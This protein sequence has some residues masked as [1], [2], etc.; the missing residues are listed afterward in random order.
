[1]S[2]ARAL[3]DEFNGKDL[4]SWNLMLCAFVE[5][6]DMV[7]ARKMFDE[8]SQKDVVSWSIMIDGYG[9]KTG[10]V[11]HARSLF[12]Q[13]N[14]RDMVTW[15]TMIDSYVKVG[16]M[17]AARELFDVMEHRNVI[18]WSSMINGYS[19]HGDPKEALN[20]YNQMLSH[21]IKADKF[22]VV[23][24]ISSCAQLGALDQGR[25]IHMYLKKKKITV[26]IVVNTALVDMYMKC[27]STEEA[28]AVFNSMSERNVVS[29]NVMISGLGI[30]GF[31]DEALT[32]FSQME[33]EG[34]Q[35]D[36]M[37][38]VSVLSA[39]SHGGFVTKG[40]E[41]F[42]RIRKPKV[43]H[44]GCLIDL[45]VRAGKLAQALNFIRSMPMEP[46]S[47]LWTSVLLGCRVQKKVR[48]GEFVLNRLKE[49]N[50][51][52]CGVYA[53]MSN[54]YA[55]NGMWEGVMKMRKLVLEKGMVKESGK[56]VIEV[57]GGGVEEFV[58]GKKARFRGNDIEKVLWSLS[59]MLD[60]EYI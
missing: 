14:K 22:C 57:V 46:N 39:C 12:D 47:D 5:C 41:I 45:L 19:Q 28:R 51:D 17:M 8:M 31:G 23:G 16:D 10:D 7:E 36:D 4:V 60:F 35:M 33:N 24:A 21:D 2:C 42:R 30:N 34:I 50:A 59:K 26:D 54:L 49:L 56:S 29:W 43:E 18:S 9:K 58:C 55:D 44:Y 32:Y 15:H 27:G 25:W 20:V 37:I 52:D 38:F 3:F 48:L 13:M 1:M 53:L 6:G 11:A 40:L